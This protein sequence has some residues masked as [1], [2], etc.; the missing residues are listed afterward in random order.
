MLPEPIYDIRKVWCTRVGEFP[1]EE[2]VLRIVV[3]FDPAH[4]AACREGT[5]AEKGCVEHTTE[6]CS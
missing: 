6:G 2:W 4:R 5:Q 3:V 1:W